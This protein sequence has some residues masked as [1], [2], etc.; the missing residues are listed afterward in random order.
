MIFQGLFFKIMTFHENVQLTGQF[1]VE[2]NFPNLDKIS[3][4]LPSNIPAIL[5]DNIEFRIN[6]I[7]VKK[8]F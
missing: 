2:T 4:I 1:K 7:I 5:K 6:S 8:K 3:K